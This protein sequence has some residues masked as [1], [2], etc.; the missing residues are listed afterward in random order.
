MTSVAAAAPPRVMPVAW[1]RATRA[2]FSI[3][4]ELD[5]G[6]RI[7]RPLVD[8]ERRLGRF[9][10]PP[11][12]RPAV[13]AQAQQIRFLE[14]LWGGLP[15][16]SYVWNRSYDAPTDGWLLD[17][18]QRWGALIAYTADEF[19]VFGYRY[20]ELSPPERRGFN[21]RP[22]ACELTGMADVAACVDVYDRLAYGGTPHDGDED[23][24]SEQP[25]ARGSCRRDEGRCRRMGRMGLGRE[26][27]SLHGVMPGE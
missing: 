13:W 16:G 8:G 1:F 20:S 5:C 10:L 9:I 22:F 15:L 17:G 7:D 24:G 11:F 26:P 25:L 6:R 19:P 2:D 27:C 4:L 18:Q 12:Q 21:N 23:D 3:N 14:S